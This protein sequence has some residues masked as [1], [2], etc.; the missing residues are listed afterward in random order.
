MNTM[1]HIH[2]HNERGAVSLIVALVL[3]FGA[4]IIAF[5]ANR[6]FIFEQRTS[7]NQYRATTSFELAEAGIEWAVG[8][9]NERLPLAATPS[10]ATGGAVGAQT[11]A[12]RFIDPQ[13]PAPPARP[14]WWFNVPVNTSYAECRFDIANLANNGGFTCSCP[15]AVA[16]G[17]IAMG[18]NEQSRFGVRFNRV[19][20]DDQSVEVIARGCTNGATCDPAQVPADSDSTSMVRVLLKLRPYI[21][22]GPTAALT[23]GAAT[24]TG[25]N[26]YVVN[27]HAPSN[28]IT[29]HAG[30]TVQTGSGTEAFTL[31]GT[32]AR[33]SIL[34]NDPSLS[35]LALAD[36]DAFFARFVGGTI[37]SYRDSAIQL[38]GDGAANGDAIMDAV[39]AGE[40]DL[41]FYAAGDVR[42]TTAIVVNG[43]AVPTIGTSDC[44][45]TLVVRGTLDMQ[46]QVVGWGLFYSANAVAD[47][48]ANPGGGG[49]TI[50][51][52][53]I[54]S[55]SFR[56]QG[57]GTFNIVYDPSLW[58]AGEPSGQLVKVPGSW[59]DF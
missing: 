20:G 18:S 35:A 32:P 39:N 31:P 55:G 21:T 8:R 13:R 25:G 58:G 43:R 5:Y 17:A 59:R 45:I 44:P 42:F 56:K 16:A 9:L 51:G 24:N 12:E 49:A 28:G 3:L 1:K 14:N 30:S 52:A 10:C 53:F 48:P 26:L 23:S 57:A 11:F 54:T 40:C 38:T 47:P 22:G 6:S 27:Q 34:D 29:I 15:S 36:E 50:N 4:T 46:G 2:R 33:A 7:V 37:A 41:Q 19:P